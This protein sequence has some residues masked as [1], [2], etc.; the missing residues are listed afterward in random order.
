MP[1]ASRGSIGLATARRVGLE[2]GKVVVSSRREENVK[3]AVTQLREEGIEAS[4][5]TCHQGKYDDRKKLMDFAKDKYGGF[6][7]V[8]MCA[9]VNPHIGNIL[10]VTESQFDKAFATNVKE[11]FLFI[12]ECLPHLE[13]RGGGSIVTNGTA[14]GSDV[15][16]A[17]IGADIRLYTVSKFTLAAMVYLVAVECF[18]RHVRVNCVI[19]GPIDTPFLAGGVQSDPFNKHLKVRGIKNTD[20]SGRIGKPSEV[21]AVVAFLLSEDS[22]YVTGEN[23]IP[24]LLSEL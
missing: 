22:S 21:A 6:D 24:M 5:T 10:T 1:R 14:A 7:S 11:N 19:P 3:E 8:F 9:G 13:E 20:P 16:M 15:G 23:D 12:R 2:G 4:G 17:F 18:N